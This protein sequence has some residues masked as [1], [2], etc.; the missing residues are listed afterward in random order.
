MANDK[1]SEPD[2]I[3]GMVYKN[4]PSVAPFLKRLVQRVF[5]TRNFPVT[6]RRIL[7]V[8]IYRVGQDPDLVSS[9]R[10]ISLLATAVK[11]VE[12]AI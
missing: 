7:L 2:M 11:I 3:P 8:P 9:R 4:F 5:K 12:T 10:P 6:L 1:T